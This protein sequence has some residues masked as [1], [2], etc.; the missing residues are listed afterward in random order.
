[1]YSDEIKEL[2]K[3]KNNIITIEEYIKI[4]NSSQINHVK[5]ENDEFKIW[6]SD[7]YSFKLKI[8]NN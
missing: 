7:G 4:I 5:Y 8:K 2:L 3:I 1:M 6:T